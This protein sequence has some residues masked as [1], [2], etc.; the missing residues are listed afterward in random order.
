[1][2]WRDTPKPARPHGIEWLAAIPVLAVVG[3]MLAAL[4]TLIVR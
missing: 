1:M 4:V 3:L 2:G